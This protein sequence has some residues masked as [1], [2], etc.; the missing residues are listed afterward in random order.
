MNNWTSPL[1]ILLAFS[2]YSVLHSILASRGAKEWA[3]Q[4]FGAGIT[5]RTYRLFYNVVGVVTLLPV[6]ALVLWL[7]DQSFYTTPPVLQPLLLAGQVLGLLLLAAALAQ[8]DALD[9]AGLR[10]LA[11]QA[12][13]PQLVTGGAYRWMRHPLYTG[14]MLV[15]WLLPSLSMNWFA[16]ILGISLYFIIGATF[17]ECRL[18]AFFGQAYHAYKA[19]TPMFIPWP[20]RAMG[21]KK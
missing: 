9:F 10:Q 16:F 4:R 17:E 7:P 21:S 8:T 19:H 2:A 11:D 13:E 15:L 20:R 5:S 18:E 12:S 1:L 14:S 6:L 3:R